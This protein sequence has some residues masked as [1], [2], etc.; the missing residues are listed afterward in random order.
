MHCQLIARCVDPR[1]GVL[2]VMDACSLRDTRRSVDSGRI[3]VTGLE[4]A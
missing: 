1:V 4:G 3:L 2:Q